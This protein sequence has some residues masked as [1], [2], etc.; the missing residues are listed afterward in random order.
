M[1]ELLSGR[2]I[3]NAASKDAFIYFFK[4]CTFVGISPP[5]N[6][7]SLYYMWSFL[8]NAICIIIA[9]IT[10]PAGFVIKYMQNIITT[11]QFLNGLQASLNLI[12]LPVKCLTVTSGL[13]RLRG[14]EP[15]LT[16]L[17]ARYTRPEDVALIRKAAVMGNR[18]VF[19][20]GTSYLMYMLFTVIPP[21]INGEAPLSVWIPFY[22]EHQSA[23]HFFGQIVYDLCL[24][25][26]VLFHQSLYDSYGSV[27][28][29]VIST[30]IQLLVRRVGRLGTDATKSE[31]DNLKELV[32]CVV[33]HQQI[34]DTQI[35]STLYFLCVLL[36]TS[37]CCY[38]ATE[39][40][41]D[42]EQLPLAIFHCNWPDQDRRFRK[43]ILYF[44]HHAQLS[45]ELMAM[46]L[47][48]INVATNISLA[49][50]SFTL[51]TFIKEM[52]IGQ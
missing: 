20:F 9:P 38:F 52:G 36:Q 22:D 44:M 48:P 4:G 47:F 23:M 42:S 40:K 10:G 8:V 27:Y 29:Y 6:A 17:D 25:G 37:P 13:N 46:Q 16:A 30:H 11:V 19:I 39:L 2:G 34:L 15:T 18:L 3:R 45:I 24:M 41:A 28:I 35:A 51:F 12:G 7:G 21:L 1:F 14:M 26:F 49:K 33:T 32:D 43:V 5:K 50:F 31:D